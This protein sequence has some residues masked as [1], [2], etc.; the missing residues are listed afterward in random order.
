[1]ETKQTYTFTVMGRPR[2]QG[3]PRAVRFGRHARVHPDPKDS[4]NQEH[5]A[6][7][8]QQHRPETPA[9]GPVWVT[10]ACYFPRPKSHYGTGRNSGK[11][12]YKAPFY[13]KSRPDCDNLAKAVLD[14]INGVYFVDDAQVCKLMVTKYY[15]ERPRTE[16]TV[17]VIE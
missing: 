7:I 5:I 6:V 16:V 17:K 11:L 4:V 1:M 12:K 10:I 9:R 13:Y 3:R 8:A 2:P 15:D 14:A